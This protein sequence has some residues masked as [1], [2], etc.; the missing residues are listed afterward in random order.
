MSDYCVYM[1]TNKINEKR[2]VGITCQS[3]SRRWRNGDGYI[4]NEHFYRAIRK[5]GWNNFEHEVI[6][7]GLSK[8]EAAELEIALIEK[9][10]CTDDRYG[11]NRSTG[12]ESPA[13]GVLISDETRKKMSDA[14]KGFTMKDSTKQKLREK[15]IA[16]GNGKQGKTGKECGKAGLVRQ[17]NFMTGEVVAEFYGY[18]EMER[19]T[20]FAK[21]PVKRAVNGTQNQSYGFRWEYIPRRKIDVTI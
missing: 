15:A 13:S 9:Y 7:T 11:Y 3:A 12:G 20:G 19:Q 18:A 1:H 10:K 21:S 6:K 5:Y 4:Q 14:H 8:K 2:Y 16:R 17:I